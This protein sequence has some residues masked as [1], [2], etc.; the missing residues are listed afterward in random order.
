MDSLILCKFLRG[1]FADLFAEWAGLLRAVTGWDVTA[2]SCAPPRA[3]IVLA[4]R[5]FNVREGAT[6]ADDWLP[7]A[8][9]HRGADRCLG[10]DRGAFASAPARDDR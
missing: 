2:T 6:R 3:R 5:A 7:R 8:L 10:A 1:V 4:K 9:P